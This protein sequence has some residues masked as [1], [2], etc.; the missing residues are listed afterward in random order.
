MP[1]INY[2]GI[3]DAKLAGPVPKERYDLRILRAVLNEHG[4]TSGKPNIEVEIE[5]PSRSTSKSFTHYL[6]FPDGEDERRDETKRAL[7]NA[8]MLSFSIQ[9]DEDGFD[10]DLFAGA[11]A[12]NMPIDLEKGNDGVERNRI[13]I[14]QVAQELGLVHAG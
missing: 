9:Y 12:Q 5:I 7:V 3:A 2:T 8:F 10:T 4:R 11:T 14:Y 13:E 1:R 6:S